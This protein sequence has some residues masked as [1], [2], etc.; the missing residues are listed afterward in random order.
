MI[1]TERNQEARAIC[2]ASTKNPARFCHLLLHPGHRM[3]LTLSSQLSRKQTALGATKAVL[4]WV[5]YQLLLMLSY[6]I[7]T[8][9]LIQT[10]VYYSVCLKS[11]GW[12]KCHYR[13]S[14][15]IPAVLA[16]K[17]HFCPKPTANSDYREGFV[18]P[19]SF[20]SLGK[21]ICQKTNKCWQF[22]MWKDSPAES[23]RTV[24]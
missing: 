7:H 11:H 17:H 21:H 12:Y 13:Q 14:N 15:K 10:K 20:L 24:G 5:S 9:L 19:A 8:K 16:S 23:E 1:Q 22:V 6:I 18:Q 4:R 3:Q 2:P